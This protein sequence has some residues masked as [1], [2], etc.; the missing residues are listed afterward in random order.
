MPIPPLNVTL[1]PLV[2]AGPIVR[3]VSKT[4]VAVWVALR[5]QGTVALEVILPANPSATPPVAATNSTTSPP[6]NTVKIGSNLHV[7]LVDFDFSKVLGSNPTAV[8]FYNLHF[9]GTVIGTLKDT[10]VLTP[11][12]E[13]F[14]NDILSYPAVTQLFPAQQG[15][16]SFVLP[17]SALTDV[18]LAQGSCRKTHADS[19]DAFVF[20]DDD[21]ANTFSKKGQASQPGPAS[22]RIQQLFLTGDQIYGDDVGD[23]T[24]AVIRDRAEKLVGET[25]LTPAIPVTATELAVGH[26]QPFVIASCGFTPDTKPDTMKSH[27]LLFG[28]Y[29]AMHLLMWSPVL[30][31]KPLSLA[32]VTEIYPPPAVPGSAQIIFFQNENNA[33]AAF[34]ATLPAVRRA[35]ANVATYMILDDHDVTDDFYMNR[36]WVSQVLASPAG[37]TVVRNGL[38]A[39]ALFQGWGNDPDNSGVQFAPLLTAVANWATVTP[40]FSPNDT[41]NLPAIAKALRIPTGVNETSPFVFSTAADADPSADPIDWDFSFAFD[42]YEILALDTRTHRTY[43]I[44]DGATAQA[45]GLIP[46][47]LISADS[48]NDQIPTGPPPW[49]APNE[50]VTIVVVPGPWTTLSVVEKKQLEAKTK[51]AFLY[52]VELL[53]FDWPTFDALVGRVAARDPQGGHVVVFCGDVH[54]SY[55]T[56][57]QYWTSDRRNP[58]DPVSPAGKTKAAIAQLVSSAIR[59]QSSPNAFPGTLALHYAGF[60]SELINIT[61]LGWRFPV[62]ELPPPLQPVPPFTVGAAQAL[63]PGTAMTQTVAWPVPV[64]PSNSTAVTELSEESKKYASVSA[65][66]Q[67]PG[68]KVAPPSGPD[69]RLQR[70]LQPGEVTPPNVQKTDGP[71]SLAAYK[72]VISDYNSGYV[73]VAKGGQQVVGVNNIGFISFIWTPTSKSVTQNSVWFNASFD[74]LYAKL[75]APGFTLAAFVATFRRLT[76]VIVPLDLP[77]DM[78]AGTITFT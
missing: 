60:R 15:L 18:R 53:H 32:S 48:L 41:T 10:G 3:R 4:K 24:L 38:L 75:S 51:N 52:D 69:W 19:I 27:L 61:R 1:L 74:Q 25:F 42:H 13:T 17:Q 72:Q 28:E 6:V 9:T 37:M 62:G 7:A 54:E 76:P 56:R 14:S 73:Q 34:V 23:S 35:L 36:K 58:L 30:W 40:T 50:G 45:S 20:L 33:I 47:G 29:C 5:S 8:Y 2:L 26:R 71:I 78:P 57:M 39:Y 49:V 22:Q 59:N 65:G 55:A 67:P 16:P 46:P 77:G 70:T 68:V 12:T 64:D 21:L 44:R 31:P 43:P 11:Q 66:V 63:L